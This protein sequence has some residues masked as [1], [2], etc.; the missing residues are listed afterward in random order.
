MVYVQF[1]DAEET[2]V[3]AVFTS[4]QDANHFPNQRELP[5]DDSRYLAYLNPL[6]TAEGLRTDLLIRRDAA[7]TA[8]DWLTFRHRDEQSAGISTTLTEN[9][10]KNLTS[11]RQSLR[12]LPASSGF[13]NIPLPAQPSF[14]K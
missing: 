2:A 7:L 11:Y 8:T 1:S 4:P 14:M 10:Y 9:Q 13:P 3:V 12:D 5:E 6:S